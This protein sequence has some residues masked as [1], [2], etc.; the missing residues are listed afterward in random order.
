MEP[1]RPADRHLR[2][3]RR[4]GG[5]FLRPRGRIARGSWLSWAR[6]RPARGGW[7]HSQG[8]RSPARSRHPAGRRRSRCSLAAADPADE[9]APSATLHLC[10]TSPLS[11]QLDWLHRGTEGPHPD[12][13]RPDSRAPGRRPPAGP[14]PAITVSPRPGRARR[15]PAAGR[16][17]PG[18]LRRCDRRPDRRDRRRTARGAELRA[19]APAWQIYQC[20]QPHPR[21]PSG[22]RPAAAQP[23]S[24]D[25]LALSRSHQPRNRLDRR[26]RTIMSRLTALVPRPRAL[27]RS[28]RDVAGV[29]VTNWLADKSAL[30]RLGASSD[31]AEWAAR[32]QRGLVRISAVTR[33]E[34][35]YSARSARTCAPT[36]GGRRWPPCP[37]GTGR[38]RS[39]TARS[40][41]SRCSTLR[42]H[43][44]CTAS[45]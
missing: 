21:R 39:R 7:L 37:L 34:V 5:S 31:A 23:N 8:V 18:R 24:L 22:E 26:G 16:G 30:V 2:A 1:A 38:R 19:P 28:G 6:S 45:V 3:A 32:I 11:C 14:A 12:A 17:N 40:R 27:C 44:P 35:G 36:W 33:L 15:A 13:R 43:E 10:L 4:P 25:N 29:A 41:S 9:D 42:L 20:G